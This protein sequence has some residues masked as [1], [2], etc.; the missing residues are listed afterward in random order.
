[1]ARVHFRFKFWKKPQ[2]AKLERRLQ[3][4]LLSLPIF[5]QDQTLALHTFLLY[6]E[7]V[8]DQDKTRETRSVVSSG[9]IIRFAAFL[10]LNYGK[11]TEVQNLTVTSTLWVQAGELFARLERYTLFSDLMLM[12]FAGHSRAI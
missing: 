6:A 1:M 12:S 3:R 4:F 11:P 9:E 8:A 7:T 5:W 2:T 10:I